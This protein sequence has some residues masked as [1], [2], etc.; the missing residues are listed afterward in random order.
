MIQQSHC[1]LPIVRKHLRQF[2]NAL[3]AFKPEEQKETLPGEANKYLPE[4]L[5]LGIYELASRVVGRIIQNGDPTGNR[6]RATSVKGR[7]PNR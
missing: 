2:R 5:V 3:A 7:C 1:L 4:K 6:T